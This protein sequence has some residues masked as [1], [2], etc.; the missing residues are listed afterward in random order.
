MSSL[1]RAFLN[2]LG[3]LRVYSLVDLII[4]LIAFRASEEQIF[5]ILSLWIGFLAYLEWRHAHVGRLKVPAWTWM[6]FFVF[7]LLL[8]PLAYTLIF[9]ALAVVYAEKIGGI[10]GLFSPFIRGL[11]MGVIALLISPIMTP[12]IFIA[13]IMI[14]MR[15]FLGDF[16][17]VVKDTKQGLET[18]PILL[19]FKKDFAYIHLLGILT[20]TFLWWSWSDLSPIILVVAWALE[21]LT[22]RLT[23]R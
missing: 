2:Y 14:A 12:H 18:W 17:D 10:F 15:N 4:F 16:R 21:V 23:P 11:Q 6:M 3:Q 8:L 20:T 22:Y 5:G 1:G 13:A 19:G 9:I 7:S